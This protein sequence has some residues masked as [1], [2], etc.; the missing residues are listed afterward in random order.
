MQELNTQIDLLK[1]ENASLK[2][3][4]NILKESNIKSQE[5]TQTQNEKFMD[6]IENLED[7]LDD[8]NT[9]IESLKKK[10][11]DKQESY[12]DALTDLNYAIN[13]GF[14]DFIYCTQCGGFHLKDDSYHDEIDYD[15][16][17]YSQLCL[18]LFTYEQLQ[19]YNNYDF[20]ARFRTY[21]ESNTIYQYC[22]DCMNDIRELYL[23][24]KSSFNNVLSNIKNMN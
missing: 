9:L 8:K 17:I 3:D 18:K 13:K 6:R 10:Y 24:H 21:Y 2:Q 20:I 23:N 22:P 7:T 15:I 11:I 14:D 5:L 12:M 1:L 19:S 4:N 16:D